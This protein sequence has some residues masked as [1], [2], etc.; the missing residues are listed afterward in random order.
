MVLLAFCVICCRA[1]AFGKEPTQKASSNFPTWIAREKIRAGYLYAKDDTKYAALMRSHG[2][3]TVIVKGQFQ[4]KERFADTLEDCR[5]WA[6]VGK[7]EKLHVFIAYNWQPAPKSWSRRG[8]PYRPL[9]YSDGST[10][11]APCPRDNKFWVG[12]LIVLGKV[13]ADLSLEPDLQIDGIFLDCELYGNRERGHKGYG[14]ET[15]FCDDCFSSFFL[16][17]GV[18]GPNLPAVE[19][20]DR[21]QWLKKKK[22]INAYS[23]FLAGDVKALASNFEREIHKINP[24]FFI[25]MYPTPTNWVLKSISRGFGTVDFPMIIFATDTYEGGGHKSIPDEPAEFY[26]NSGIHGLYAAGFILGCYDNSRLEVS[27]Y[28]AAEKCGGYWLWKMPM[29]WENKDPRFQISPDTPQQYWRSIGRA[30]NDINTLIGETGAS[31]DKMNML[32]R[33]RLLNPKAAGPEKGESRLPRVNFR[34]KQDF[35]FY[36]DKQLEA[37]IKLLFKRLAVYAD[38]LEYKVISPEGRTILIKEVSKQGPIEINFKSPV[39]GVYLLRVN[40]G[41]CMFRVESSNNPIAAL[42]SS[43]FN[44]ILRVEPVYF[45]IGSGSEKVVIVGEGTSNETFRLTTQAPKGQKLSVES[46]PERRGLRVEI[47]GNT[48]QKGIWSLKISKASKGN[49]EDAYFNFVGLRNMC[50][51]YRPEWI[52]VQD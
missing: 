40:V 24:S 38:N 37:H 12:Y 3:N 52:F 49:L 27:L 28:T 16:K 23:T 22:L 43:G 29:L 50:L 32:Q 1:I 33:W 44:T 46:S 51:A 42:D 6:R 7:K 34:G 8:Y 13:A 45:Y 19:K 48:V 11:V 30:N 4:F 2:L 10:G 31:M 35:L 20:T 25:G 9:V 39:T 26:R 47:D 18:S 41:R 5:Q 36:A 17:R 15:C 21:A 14:P